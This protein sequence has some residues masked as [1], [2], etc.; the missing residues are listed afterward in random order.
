[1]LVL[2]VTFT[3]HMALHMD[4]SAK[5]R[6]IRPQ[7]P[8]KRS[9]GSRH[10]LNVCT[11]Y[12]LPSTIVSVCLKPLPPSHAEAA[13]P[14]EI[15]LQGAGHPDCGRVRHSSRVATLHRRP[16][17]RDIDWDIAYAA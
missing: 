13:H 9:S 11:G 17:V 6:R 8:H 12:F 14:P 10:D 7:F 16:F 2:I 5:N 1:M 3:L 4:G 15:T